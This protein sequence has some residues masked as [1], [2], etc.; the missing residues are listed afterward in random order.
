MAWWDSDRVEYRAELKTGALAL[1]EHGWPLLPGTYWQANRWT[2]VPDA[3]RFGP[4]PCVGTN[5]AT[6]D[7]E[8]VT[9]WW[10]ELPYSVLLA[11]GSVVDVIEVSALVG[12]RVCAALRER[13]VVVPVATSPIGRWWFAVAAGEALR[14]ELATRPDLTLHGRGSVVAAPPTLGPQGSMT[15]RVA[16]STCG[17][18]LPEAR[19][20][21]AAMLDV[22]GPAPASGV[23]TTGLGCVATGVRS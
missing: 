4:T 8:T 15:W 17:W 1:A 22:L 16:P 6:D 5:E 21:Q 13:G 20:L 11:T 12:R 2:G 3:P 14:P 18:R 7:V 10:S 19:D 23:P 9:G